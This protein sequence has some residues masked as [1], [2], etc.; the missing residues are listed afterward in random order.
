MGRIAMMTSATAAL[1]ISSSALGWGWEAGTRLT[2]VISDD[3]TI[4]GMGTVGETELELMLAAGITGVA[5]LLVESPDGTMETYDVVLESDGTILVGDDGAF[6]DLRDLAG[7]SGRGVTIAM[8]VPAASDGDVSAVGDVRPET[9][10]ER[11]SEVA[12]E[13]ASENA[14][15][16]LERA[17]DAGKGV[18]P[19]VAER[20]PAVPEQGAAP[21]RRTSQER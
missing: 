9:G 5:V 11:A 10:L 1:M 17:R 6:A 14:A 7:E 12:R 15:E 20:D 2:L 19:N 13:V 8:E 16:G 18:A 21:G 4:V 3:A